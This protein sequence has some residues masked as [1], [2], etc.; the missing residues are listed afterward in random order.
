VTNNTVLDI[1]GSSTISTNP[2]LVNNT[3]I[4]VVASGLSVF[5]GHTDHYG[6]LSITG[7]GTVTA[8]SGV[9]TNDSGD[10]TVSATIV[11][12]SYIN[13]NVTADIT[14]SGAVV[15][16]AEV[17]ASSIWTTEPLNTNAFNSGAM[18]WGNIDA[19]GTDNILNNSVMNSG[20]LG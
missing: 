1:V 15:S 13:N 8:S 3:N 18:G 12:S 5:A 17:E 19:A 9:E 14:L 2:T 10:V 4:D 6:I 20:T 16:I 7:T 11:S